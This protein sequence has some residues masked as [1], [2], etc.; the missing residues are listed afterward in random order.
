MTSDASHAPH[1]G[2]A[3]IGFLSVSSIQAHVWAS[4]FIRLNYSTPT[5]SLRVSLP[6]WA[7]S[8]PKFMGSIS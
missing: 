2:A 6:F 1:G 4:K 3:T 5:L 7:W 8:S